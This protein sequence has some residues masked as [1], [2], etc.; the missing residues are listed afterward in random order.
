MPRH[1]KPAF[2]NLA[3]DELRRALKPELKPGAWKTMLPI[4]VMLLAF[5]LLG[6]YLNWDLKLV[7][8]VSFV[9]AII[10]NLFVWLLGLV[11]LLPVVGPL[12]VKL[13]ALPL[14][15]LLN[16][17]GYFLALVAIRR[18]Y[19]RDVITY[20]ALTISLIIGIFIGFLLGSLLWT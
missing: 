4:L 9:F 18:G 13:L 12:I 19:T 16:A 5:I 11:A 15:W 10:S 2:G 17:I 8:A 20:R 14:I 6:V 7:A 3:P 1:S